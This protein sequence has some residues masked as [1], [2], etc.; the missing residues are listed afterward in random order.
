MRG[1]GVSFFDEQLV[2][3]SIHGYVAGSIGV[4]FSVI[5]FK[6][7]PCKFLPFPVGCYLVVLIQGF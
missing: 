3:V 7:D 5:P 1:L 4:L 6:A 2:Y